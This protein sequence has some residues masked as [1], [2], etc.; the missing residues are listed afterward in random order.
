MVFELTFEHRASADLTLDHV[1]R[2][3]V[4]HVLLYSYHWILLITCGTGTHSHLA[5]VSLVL[6]HL[7]SWHWLETSFAFGDLTILIILVLFGVIVILI[8]VVVIGFLA[9][10]TLMFASLLPKD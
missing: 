3:T 6:F 2:Y 9:R 4:L 10:G 7:R 8:I 5:V 1:F